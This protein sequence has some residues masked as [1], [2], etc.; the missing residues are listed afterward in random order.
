MNQQLDKLK[1]R[2]AS[3]YPPP[4]V[5]ALSLTH[6]LNL[7]TVD[8]NNEIHSTDEQ[9][10]ITFRNHPEIG[11]SP[12]NDDVRIPFSSLKEGNNTGR[13]S[14]KTK[15][16]FRI[17]TNIKPQIY[18]PSPLFERLKQAKQPYVPKQPYLQ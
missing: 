7:N 8:Q 14:G 9:G 16:D 15:A 5:S 10:T 18:K 3:A 12:R 13:D 2:P 6:K 17:S 11:S 4:I 1:Q